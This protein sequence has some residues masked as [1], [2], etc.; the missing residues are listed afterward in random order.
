MTMKS[1]LV[2]EVGSMKPTSSED[3]RS[4]HA[5]STLHRRRMHGGERLEDQNQNENEK[6]RNGNNLK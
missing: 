1:I 4:I 3:A 2:I 6:D 5:T